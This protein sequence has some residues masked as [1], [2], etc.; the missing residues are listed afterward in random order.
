M[1][2][3]MNSYAQEQ[4]T[5]AQSMTKQDYIQKSK[6]QKT[7]AWIM[8]GGGTAMAVGGM[9]WVVNNLFEPDQGE[10]V[11]FFMGLGAM[12]GSI[13]LFIASGRNARK[14]A[15]MSVNLKLERPVVVQGHI[16]SRQY[17]P[18]VSLQIGLR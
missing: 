18:A 10:S 6:N 1:L 9:V 5:P 17:L 3:C 14:A 15:D 8:L 11:V 7:T 12:I 16:I 2:L 4:P 13:P